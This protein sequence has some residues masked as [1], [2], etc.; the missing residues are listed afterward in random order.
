MGNRLTCMN[1]SYLWI[2]IVFIKGGL[3]ATPDSGQSP[4][5]LEY[6]HEK[7]DQE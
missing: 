7:R 3:Y 2:T 6:G 4:V 5:F 1:H